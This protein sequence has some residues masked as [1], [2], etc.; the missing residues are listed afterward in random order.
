MNRWMAVCLA[1]LGTTLTA[2]G[3]SVVLAAE[4]P[5]SNT[6]DLRPG[7]G[8]FKALGCTSCPPGAVIEGE[9]NCGLPVDDTNGGCNF[10]P[11]VYTDLGC[12]DQTVCGTGGWDGSTRDT[13]WY[14]IVLP[15]PV[16]SLTASVTAEFGPQLAIID[17]AAS[18]CPIFTLI[19]NEDGVACTELTVST[20][21]L[22]AG[23]YVVFVAP[24]IFD[25][26]FP[27]GAGYTLT[28]TGCTPAATEFCCNNGVCTEVPIGTCHGRVVENCSLC[29]HGDHDHE[30][31]KGGGEEW[32]ALGSGAGVST[33]K[34]V[35]GPNPFRE[36]TQVG[37][38][39]PSTV[40]VRLF[41]Y[42]VSG[43]VVDRL[44]EATQGAGR[45]S[46]SWD[47]SQQP[48]GTYFFRLDA[49]NEVRVERAT[50]TR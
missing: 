22:A 46:V 29:G 47:G 5:L 6:T 31:V 14:R 8:E 9:A 23:T 12:A 18:T 15:G 16:A 42:D 19:V 21:P 24:S 17:L 28:V 38:A 20:G 3:T 27:C 34:L 25:P 2:H 40:P 45:Y 41:V 36:T 48:S 50:L 35:L 49:G 7:P 32:F 4:N 10:H 1:I 39:L 30:A 43:R 11:E 37:Y 26:G 44:V 33:A 13:D